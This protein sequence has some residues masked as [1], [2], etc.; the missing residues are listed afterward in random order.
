MLFYMVV[1]STTPPTVANMCLSLPELT[2]S[3]ISLGKK[4]L[5]LTAFNNLNGGQCCMA[6]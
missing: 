5:S 4:M 1:L 2:L 3:T 6:I